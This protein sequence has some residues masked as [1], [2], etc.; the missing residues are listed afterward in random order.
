MGAWRKIDAAVGDVCD[1]LSRIIMFFSI[2]ETR[3][4]LRSRGGVFV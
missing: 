4:E 2:H 1:H 3:N